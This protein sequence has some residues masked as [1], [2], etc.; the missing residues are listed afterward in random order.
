MRIAFYLDKNPDHLW[1]IN[2]IE[3]AG[4]G[5]LYTSTWNLAMEMQHKGHDV[6]IWGYI[7][8]PDIYDDIACRD[9]ESDKTVSKNDVIIGVDSLPS[10]TQITAP[11]KILWYRSSRPDDIIKENYDI[12][13]LRSKAQEK[14]L[15]DKITLPARRRIIPCGVNKRFYNYQE[16]PT[17]QLDICFSGHPIKGMADLVPFTQKLRDVR[18][19]KVDVHAYGNAEIWGWDNDEFNLLYHDMIKNGILYHGRH[20]LKTIT[21]RMNETKVFIYPCSTEEPMGVPV[22]EAMGGGAVPIVSSIGNLPEIVPDE[23][24]YVIEGTPKDFAWISKSVEKTLFLLD[25]KN[26]RERMSEK[27]KSFVMENYNWETIAEKWESNVL[28]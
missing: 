23:C 9:I 27:A 4:L 11:K 28:L 1:N 20:G 3:N 10:G 12:L 24:G 25:H 14:S 18:K 8:D 15:S 17:R 26:E 2:T 22:L 13:V 19:T 5:S 7:R 21:R 16:L 6:T